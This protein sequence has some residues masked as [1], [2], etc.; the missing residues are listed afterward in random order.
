MFRRNSVVRACST[1]LVAAALIAGPTPGA[2][3][4]APV[5]PT[6]EST[7]DGD[8]LAND[9]SAFVE[10]SDTLWNAGDR[11][12]VAGDAYLP[13]TP[14]TGQVLSDRDVLVS[15]Y[16]SVTGAPVWSTRYDRDNQRIDDHLVDFHLDGNNN[17]AYA[18]INSGT[19]TLVRK[20]AAS[21]GAVLTSGTCSGMVIPSTRAN[22]AAVSYPGGWIGIAGSRG[23]NFYVTSRGAGDCVNEFEDTPVAGEALSA[24]I[25]R[26]WGV[27]RTMMVTG[28]ESTGGGD[29]YTA[30]YRYDV[31]TSNPNPRLWNAR[32]SSPTGGKDEGVASELAHV[33]ALGHRAAFVAGRSYSS[34]EKFDTVVLA[35][36][37][38][39]GRP[40]WSGNPARI[41]AGA[42]HGNDEPIDIRYSDKTGILYVLGTSERGFPHGT[43]VAV[44]AYNAMTGE[45][46]AT[47]YVS[48]DI[49]NG[50]DKATGIEVSSDGSRVV[51]SA[52]IHNLQGT[53]GRRGGVFAFDA[54]LHPAGSGLLT[55]TDLNPEQASAVDFAGVWQND[56]PADVAVVVAG[57]SVQPGRGYDQHVARFP[58]PAFAVAPVTTSL[59]FTA[60][61]PSSVTRG[62]DLPVE[63]QL[64]EA[65]GRAARNREVVVTF[66]GRTATVI[67]DTTG[68][69]ST[70]FS[71]DMDT[72]SYELAARF[73]GAD[74]LEPSAASTTVQIT[75]TPAQL[76]F[77]D[78]TS[79]SV[80]RD[81]SA[82]FRV[83]LADNVTGPLAGAAVRV[84]A[85]GRTVDV[86]TDASGI[87]AGTLLMDVAPGQYNMVTT[88]TG[89]AD[90]EPATAT[91]PLVVERATTALRFTDAS[92]TAGQYSDRAQIEAVLERSG[93]PVAGEVVQFS[94]AGT[95]Y[96]AT[97]DALGIARADMLLAQPP[98]S[99][100]VDV[101]YAGSSDLRPATASTTITVTRD[102]P[103]LTLVVAG[104][105]VNREL[106]ATL[107]D[108]DSG[109]P[110]ANR[111]VDFTADGTFAGTAFTDA[112]GVARLTNPA[113]VRSKKQ[114]FAATFAGDDFYLPS[115]T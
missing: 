73:A 9:F 92:A 90:H 24:D 112:S 35:Y 66:A 88:F 98:G 42:F 22:D 84:S 38:D 7:T 62:T 65:D 69:A 89:D 60:A 108:L 85:A 97:T 87:A 55:S 34:A 3:A 105:G 6:W 58:L 2:R 4:A 51:V 93:S 25:P 76:A 91:V 17:I 102:D 44:H 23:S 54:L 114:T 79:T 94:A 99:L 28:R 10:T 41:F 75:K 39:T 63:V 5:A 14:S 115:S 111:R 18:I 19:D 70:T 53:G 32:W 109:A 106:R 101:A 103:R 83:A 36:D 33:S 64:R 57:A 45:H 50:D 29:I 107:T 86:V 80:E 110:L 96:T 40:L 56:K 31:T 52:E 82:A 43:D 48:G 49:S 12:Y 68:R 1:A 71:T 21:S 78:G 67:T 81:T 11:V 37:Y 104:S 72:G 16:D 74:P 113:G 26:D 95:N 47:A 61:T 30:G 59:Q 46:I 13:S 77:L 20:F 27:G 100:A 15:A 8:L